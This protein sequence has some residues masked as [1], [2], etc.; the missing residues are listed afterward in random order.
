VKNYKKCGSSSLLPIVNE[1]VSRLFRSPWC[2]CVCLC[3]K[4]WSSW[5]FSQNLCEQ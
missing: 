2:L 4:F 1:E 3:F 5:R